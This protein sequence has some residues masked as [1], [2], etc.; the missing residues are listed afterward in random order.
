MKPARLVQLSSQCRLHYDGKLYGCI[1]EEYSVIRKA[2]LFLIFN[3]ILIS[4]KGHTADTEYETKA[5]EVS[6][7]C[8]RP[9]PQ[10]RP[11]PEAEDLSRGNDYIC[12]TLT[13]EIEL[14]DKAS[15]T[16]PQD[17]QIM[18]GSDIEIW[19]RDRKDKDGNWVIRLVEDRWYDVYYSPIE[20]I[21]QAA[22]G[23]CGDDLPR[24]IPDE[25]IDN[26]KYIC[27]EIEIPSGEVINLSLKL[28]SIGLPKTQMTKGGVSYN[29]LSKN[30]YKPYLG[31]R[32]IWMES[33]GTY[34]WWFTMDGWPSLF[35]V[36]RYKTPEECGGSPTP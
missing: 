5:M 8:E 17:F 29:F 1:E 22:D 35:H 23:K 18:A 31:T 15:T 14:Y 28:N 21:Y 6:P 13:N 19:L 2:I 3:L 24:T 11:R 32:K 10:P 20:P 16:Y 4:P 26:N 34:N 27:A 36:A 25:I 12:V 9:R 30:K 33:G 7:C